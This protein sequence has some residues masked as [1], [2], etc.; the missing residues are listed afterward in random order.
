MTFATILSEKTMSPS[1]AGQSVASLRRLLGWKAS[2]FAC[3]LALSGLGWSQATP[4]TPPDDAPC[5]E[6]DCPDTLDQGGAATPLVDTQENPAMGAWPNGGGATQANVPGQN[7]AGQRD[8]PTD[9]WPNTAWPNH[10]WPDNPWPNHAPGDNG[11]GGNGETDRVRRRA[12]PFREDAVPEP[13]TE[14]QQFVSTRP[15]NFRPRRSGSGD[16]RLPPRTGR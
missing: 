12:V 3:L 6:Q 1:G 8:W 16:R 2:A 14:F 11:P 4:T 9:P 13:P 10:A 15:D 7:P 5:L